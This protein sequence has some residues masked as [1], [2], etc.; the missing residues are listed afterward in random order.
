MPDLPVTEYSDLHARPGIGFW[1]GGPHDEC[2]ELPDPRDHV[3]IT[4]DMAEQV[5]VADA[6]D[7]APRIMG[8]RGI[9]RCRICGRMNGSQTL[10]HRNGPV[11][12]E[13]FGHYVRDHG[14]RPSADFIRWLLA[15]AATTP[16][17][18]AAA[19]EG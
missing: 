16:P 15:P 3:D 17:G 2:A 1:R 8:W 11:W 4:W 19:V 7:A 10:G 18:P 6:L 5:A 9:S 14:V 13:G 12:P